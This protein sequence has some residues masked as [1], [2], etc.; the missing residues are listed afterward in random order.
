MRTL[1][2]NE[3][4]EVNGA[5]NTCQAILM[6]M[7]G[8]EG[9]LLSGGNPAGAFVGAAAGHWLGDWMGGGCA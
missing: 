4:E 6:G 2:M 8:M 7:G 5:F 9:F 1:S 3:I